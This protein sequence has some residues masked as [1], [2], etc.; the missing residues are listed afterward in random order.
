[1]YQRIALVDLSCLFKRTFEANPEGVLMS[2][3]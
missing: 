3:L 2:F 1:M